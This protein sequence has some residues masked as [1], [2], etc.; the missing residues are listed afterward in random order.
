MFVA[1]AEQQVQRAIGEADRILFLLDA[2]DGLTGS[3][4]AERGR[5]EADE[6]DRLVRVSRIYALALQ[7]FEGDDQAALDWLSGEQ[8][9]LGGAKPFDLVGSEIGA[10]EVVGDHPTRADDRGSG[11]LQDVGL[12]GEPVRVDERSGGGSW[13]QVTLPAG[14]PD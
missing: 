1:T 6:S 12:A 4:E 13:G 2:R 7:L 3:D 10:R 9:G 11:E 5:F 14:R 8:V